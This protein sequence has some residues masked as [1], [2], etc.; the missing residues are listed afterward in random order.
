MA[1]SFTFTTPSGENVTFTLTAQ[2]D[3]SAVLYSENFTT[4]VAGAVYLKVFETGDSANPITDYSTIEQGKLYD[5]EAY[6]DPSFTTPVNID[7]WGA[8]GAEFVG[9]SFVPDR[10]P[11]AHFGFGNSSTSDLIAPS[12]TNAAGM[13]WGVNSYL[14]RRT[15]L[16]GSDMSDPNTNGRLKYANATAAVVAGRGFERMHYWNIAGFTN[17]QDNQ[18]YYNSNP[19]TGLGFTEAKYIQDA[20]DITTAVTSPSPFTP[21]GVDGTPGDS[22]A[23]WTYAIQETKDLVT[24]EGG[25]PEVG[26]YFGYRAFYDAADMETN[27]RTFLGHNPDWTGT[28]NSPGFLASTGFDYVDEANPGYSASDEAYNNWFAP[29]LAGLYSMGFD[30]VGLDVGAKIFLNTKGMISLGSGINNANPPFTTGDDRLIDL[31]NS[32]GMKPYGEAIP[33]ETYGI[34]GDPLT[35]ANAEAYTDMAYMG[36]WKH[37]VGYSGLDENSDPLVIGAN[38]TIYNPTAGDGTATVG[39]NANTWDSATTEIHCVIRWNNAEDLN[40][41]IGKDSNGNSLGYGWLTMKQ[42]LYDLHTAGMIISISGSVGSSMTDGL[43]YEITAAEFH[44]YVQ[45]LADGTITARPEPPAAPVQTVVWTGNG[46]GGVAGAPVTTGI[47]V[48]SPNNYYNALQTTGGNFR[49]VFGDEMATNPAYSALYNNTTN[50]GLPGERV[51][52]NTTADCVTYSN[53][54]RFRI[55]KDAGAWTEANTP[56]LGGGATEWYNNVNSSQ[57]NWQAFVMGNDTSEYTIEVYL[58]S[59]LI[60]DEFP[61]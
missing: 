23:A 14:Y 24:A 50:A 22:E 61:D 34:N 10:R 25:T 12:T 2:A 16:A 35:G 18:P 47:N 37:S 27:D 58:R 17:Y 5:I 59:D 56:F 45:D 51:N 36:F 1:N 52:A 60:N 33:M 43:G 41:L 9:Y 53:N 40:I 4:S 13:H 20:D 32:Y 42:V 39:P 54:Y 26:V 55:R 57:P 3:G 31:F 7:S 15:P 49:L 38:T 30:T 48:L 44:Q 6:S 28:G 29:E 46:T 21:N 19:Y 8:S 11:I